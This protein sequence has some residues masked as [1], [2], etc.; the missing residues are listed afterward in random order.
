MT[1]HPVPQNVIEV[2]FKL[3]GS[4]TLKQFSKILIGGLIGVVL[5]LLP[6]PGVIKYP[7]SFIS[8]ILGI[9]MAVTPALGTW[10]T[11]FIKALFLSPRY[12][13]IREAT[14]PDILRA[15]EITTTTSAKEMKVGAAK[16]TNKLDIDKLD[17]RQIYGNSPT[18]TRV[19]APAIQSGQSVAGDLDLKPNKTSEDNFVRVYEDVFGE[20]IFNRAKDS[21][22]DNLY[23]QEFVDKP[24]EELNAENKL[25]SYKKEIEDLKY[26]LSMLE[27]DGS[28]KLKE[29]QILSKINDIYREIKVLDGSQ[30][31]VNT[32]Q[33]VIKN[34]SLQTTTVQGKIINGIIVDKKDVPIPNAVVSFVNKQ[35]NIIYRTKSTTDGKFTTGNP[36]PVGTYAVV[37]EEQK[38]SFHTYLVE[39][40]NQNLPAFKFREK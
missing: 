1:Q 27:K 14:P 40:E 3:F 31:N 30:L 4:F 28:Y 5:F 12:V 8:I 11:G 6:L 9:G 17:L 37:I 33:P 22:L 29:E 19:A 38:H 25:Q 36:I 15:K 18:Q 35:K 21:A 34:Q 2:E 13:W 10:L 16:K 23:K 26:Q 39:V 32:P 7:L 24:K 20:G